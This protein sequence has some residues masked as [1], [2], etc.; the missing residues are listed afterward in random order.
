MEPQRL[1]KGE[2]DALSRRVK[3]HFSTVRYKSE[4][5]WL[6]ENIWPETK[7]RFLILSLRP[8]N[9][10][11]LEKTPV[12]DIVR[13]VEALDD[14]YYAAIPSLAELARLYGRPDSAR[15]F[16]L[17]DLHLYW[18]QRYLDEHKEIALDMND[19]RGHFSVRL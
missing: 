5:E 15:M 14:T 4:A 3:E 10:G 11:H 18:Q 13:E 6:D 7:E 16:C 19:E 12:E 8:E 1:T 17:R 9:I 2:F